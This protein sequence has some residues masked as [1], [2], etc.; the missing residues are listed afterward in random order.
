MSTVHVA[1]ESHAN[2][3]KFR[4][5]H[6][7][8]MGVLG[9][10]AHSPF[11]SSDPIV[12]STSTVAIV[13][14]GFAGLAAALMCKD[15][16]KTSD[17]VVFDKHMQWGGTW[18]ANTY[19]G[20]ASDIPALWYSLFG[21]LNDNWSTLRP[22]Q[23]EMEEY[24]LEVVKRRDLQKH[25]RFGVIVEQMVYNQDLGSWTIHA[26]NVES[27][28]RYEHTSTV[29]FSC[30]GGL[31]QPQQLQAPGLHDRFQGEY[32]HSALWNHAVDFTDKNVVVVGNGC[33]AVQVVP[34][35]VD[36][37][38]VKS[39]TQ[40][41]RSKHWIRRP[42]PYVLQLWYKLAAR[43]RIGLVALRWFVAVVAELNYPMFQGNGPVARVLRWLNMRSCRTYVLQNSPE[44]YHLM[45]IPDYKIGCK[46][47]ICDYKYVPTLNNPK[48]QL[49]NSSIE[50]VGENWVQF[51]DGSVADADIIVACTGYDLSK[52]YADAGSV[53][54]RNGISIKKLWD[55]EGTS[56][57]R[58][59]M[60]RDCPNF[61]L[62]GGPNSATGHSSVVSAIENGC[63]LAERAIRPVLSGKAKSVMVKR[64]AYYSWFEFTQDLLSR[65]VYGSDFG[66]CHSWYAAHGINATTYPASQVHFWLTSRQDHL[67]D[68]VYEPVKAD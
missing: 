67:K 28:Q 25:A 20:C 29:V 7:D 43:T 40:V 52:S 48:V 65:G 59:V 22:P 60:V 36:E 27:G 34:A 31:V 32:M 37:L 17:F 47:T 64:S 66:G 41:F 68:M 3:T 14:A 10:N 46:R 57:Y 16:L 5:R 39:V 51:A 63:A 19:P 53:V 33:S 55:K 13:G 50:Q 9:P 18:W 11:P 15:K 23:Y 8:A 56:A 44:K 26:I 1:R 24:I 49:K 54:G 38:H 62:L 6:E 45:L 58:T 35:L 21:E 4:I 12:T 30:K 61:F 42:L 2:R